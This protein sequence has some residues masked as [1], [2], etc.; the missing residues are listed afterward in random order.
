MTEFE[1]PLEEA[2]DKFFGRY[3]DLSDKMSE[4]EEK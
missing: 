4:F 3:F 1:N 2:Y